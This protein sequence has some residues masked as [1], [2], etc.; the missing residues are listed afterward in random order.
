[1][2][3]TRS[4][5]LVEDN[6]DDVFLMRRAFQEAGL[7]NPLHVVED[8]QRAIDYLAGEGPFSNR[9]EFPLPSLVLLDWKL[10]R[11]SGQEVL[12]W[13]RARAEFDPVLVVVLTSSSEERDV[14][15]AYSRKANSYLVK[16]PTAEELLELLK[17]FRS[18]WIGHNRFARLRPP[19]AAR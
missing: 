9:D 8:G 1:M 10:P 5:L 15:S 13:I 14:L 17:S 4:I 2:N 11:R 12:A 18:Y 3:T 19:A 16:P 7:T 6:E